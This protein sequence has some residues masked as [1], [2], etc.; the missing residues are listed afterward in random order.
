MW[1]WKVGLGCDDGLVLGIG[2]LWK[3]TVTPEI[4]SLWEVVVVSL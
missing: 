3:R 1:I 2:V 4:A